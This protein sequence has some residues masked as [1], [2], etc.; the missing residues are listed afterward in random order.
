MKLYAPEMNTLKVKLENMFSDID[1]KNEK[2]EIIV[3]LLKIGN[4]LLS[5][6]CKL[7]NTVDDF[8]RHTEMTLKIQPKNP[9]FLLRNENQFESSL[10]FQ[11]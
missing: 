10:I 5:S 2:I 1:S 3:E 8:G 11:S 4:Y 7:F 9:N 6:H